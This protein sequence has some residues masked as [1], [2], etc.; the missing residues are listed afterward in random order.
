M[1]L[2]ILDRAFVLLRRFFRAECAEASAFA[3]L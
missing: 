1:T 3:G 2:E